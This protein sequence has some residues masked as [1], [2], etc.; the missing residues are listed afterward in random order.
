MET[1][2]IKIEVPQGYEIDK[3]KST[4]ENIILKP[5]EVKLP[6]SVDDIRRNWYIDQNGKIL[7]VPTILQTN[8]HL[9][10][11][12]RAKAFL[13]LMQLVELRDAWNGDWRADWKDYD[14]KYSICYLE[15][16]IDI[17]LNQTR[18]RVLHF[19][20]RE[21]AEK[22]AE[23]FKDLINEAKELL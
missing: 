12:T 14:N 19:K 4:F 8:N 11:E 17:F 15:E 7:N 6:L 5:I 9:S 1:K 23:Q 2:Q 16:E 3:E 18:R 13:A 10:T 22:F 20:T 21:L